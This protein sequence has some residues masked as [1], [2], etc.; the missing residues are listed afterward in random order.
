MRIFK[1]MMWALFAL[2]VV[3]AAA[4]AWGR[5]RPPTAA[6]QS[7]WA[8]LHKDLKPAQGRNAAPA[9]W[10]ADFAVPAD[11]LD[12]AYAKE[13]ARAQTWLDTHGVISSDPKSLPGPQP[14]FPA[15]PRLSTDD[16]A[17]LCQVKDAD[18]LGKVRAHADDV[19]ALLDKYRERLENDKALSG[20]D[21]AWSEMPANPLVMPSS[22]MASQGLWQSDIAL[23]FAD[24]ERAQALQEACTQVATMRRLHA[25]S[26]M[27]IDQLLLAVRLRAAVRLFAGLLGDLAIDEPLPAVCAAAFAPATTQDVDLCAAMQSEFAFTEAMSA[28]DG[29]GRWYER[30]L[31]S[32]KDSLRLMSINPA[33]FCEATWTRRL[34]ADE[35]VDSTVAFPP[36]DLFDWISNA[37]GVVLSRIATPAWSGYAEREQDTAAYQRMGALLIWLRDT[38]SSEGSVMQRVA[39]RPAWMVFGADRHLRMSADGRSLQLDLRQSHDQ[40]EPAW[41]LPAMR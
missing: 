12:V 33:R 29:E 5:L 8:L 15:L 34:L 40:A 35:A 28:Q 31:W 17:V 11:Q 19:R 21:Y 37:S 38:S 32:R 6:Q 24:G 41:P 18:C 7:A 39:R 1:G 20:Y 13:H 25:H 3:L 23:R 14:P 30:V 22:V 36:V 9:L 2:L 4:F 16:R 10:F 27:L 26:N